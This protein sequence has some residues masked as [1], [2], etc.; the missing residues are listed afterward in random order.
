MNAHGDNAV[1][2]NL[3]KDDDENA[4]GAAGSLLL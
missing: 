3:A 4:D 2:H 1:R